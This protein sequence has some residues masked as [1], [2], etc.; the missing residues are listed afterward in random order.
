M[1]IQGLSITSLSVAEAIEQRRSTKH[2]LPDP[3]PSEVFDR[4]IELTL[5]APSSWNFQPWRIVAVKNLEQKAKLK[6]AAYNQAQ[7]GEAPVTFVFAA[8]LNSWEET[9]EQIIEQALQASAWSEKYAEYM[10]KSV[11]SFQ[12]ALASHNLLR[13]YVVKDAMIAATHCALAAE[14]LG[15]GSTFMNGWVEEKVKDVIGVSKTA[16]EQ[17]VIAILLPVGYPD[18]NS[19]TR[20]PGRLVKELTL[21]NNVLST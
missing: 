1:T 14:S 20:S 13:E 17:Y 18:P 6:E 2:F 7:I 8:K 4:L 3:I 10:R 21:F 5:L 16:R 12:K 9:I 11:P 19:P 15:L